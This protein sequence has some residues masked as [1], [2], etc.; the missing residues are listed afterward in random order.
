MLLN[1]DV[2]KVQS[3]L[4]L[5]SRWHLGDGGR[6]QV[7]QGGHQEDLPALPVSHSRQ[8]D[9]QRAPHAQTH[10]PWKCQY[11]LSLH[12]VL[13][14][15]CVQIIGL[16]DVFTP[17]CS[18]DE[19]SDVYMVT[20][21]MGADLNNIIRTQRWEFQEHN[22]FICPQLLYFT[23]FPMIMFSFWFT[24]LSGE[25][26]MFTQPESFTGETGPWLYDSII[27]IWCSL[28]FE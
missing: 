14:F 15:L 11:T 3:I 12:R 13:Y 6:W 26:N 28:Q 2:T 23:G 17:Q 20:H 18:L 27:T 8:E 7:P 5:L 19:F 24:K 9:L 22:P 25:W 4:G 10:G 1:D 21:L 16:L